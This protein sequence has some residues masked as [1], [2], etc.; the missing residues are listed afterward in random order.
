[1]G[2][3]MLKWLPHIRDMNGILK[4][5]SCYFGKEKFPERAGLPSLSEISCTEINARGLFLLC[6]S[7]CSYTAQLIYTHAQKCLRFFSLWQPD[8]EVLY[9]TLNKLLKV[10]KSLRET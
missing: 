8:L 5:M 2:L 9:K 7:Y 10:W 6:W 3:R 1:M 4:R